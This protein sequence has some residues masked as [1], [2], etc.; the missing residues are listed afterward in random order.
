M[1]GYIVRRLLQ[2]VPV[3]LGI[4]MVVFIVVHLI[5]G[6]PVMVMLGER[7][8]PESAERLREELGLNDPLPVQYV[9]YISN[10][11]RGDLG[12][13]VRTNDHVA[14]EILIRYPATVELTLASLLIAI[15]GGMFL[16]IVSAVK[17]Y[18][19]ADQAGMV[20]ALFGVS[21]P[22]FWLG[23]M[24]ILVFGVWLHWL[25]ISGRLSSDIPLAII[26]RFNLIDSV[27][28]RN[29]PAFWDSLKRLVLPA[30]T[31]GSMQMAIVA[32]MTRS[33]MLEVIRQDYVRTAR[34]KGLPERVV[35]YKHALKNALIPV[36]T[37][38]G[39]TF[40]RLLGGAVL[41]ETI[42]GW[43]GVG[44]FA[45]QAILARDYPMVQGAVLLIALGFV[46]VNL[47]IDVTYVF[48][49]PRIRYQ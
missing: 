40:G 43:P 34:A 31:L 12:R 49:D 5:P 2:L 45:V 3:L 29:S 44:R 9:H 21:I 14:I 7:A 8:T 11:L 26:T 20:V 46:L 23:L 4:S 19:W 42:F 48:L 41:T 38:V 27:I 24:L 17:Q 35:I 28:T 30:V 25:P 18:S 36:V 22:V 47:I 32:R 16:G 15:F 37:V 39:L 13:S 33:S 1:G 6:D 10:A